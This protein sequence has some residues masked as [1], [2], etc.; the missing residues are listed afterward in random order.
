MKK[1]ILELTCIL[2]LAVI[3]GCGLTSKQIVKSQSFGNATSNIG[4]FGERE[5]LNIRNG[6]I[7]MNKELV[8]I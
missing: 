1:V 7:T 6:I 3:T 5:F 8:A 4:R 2:V